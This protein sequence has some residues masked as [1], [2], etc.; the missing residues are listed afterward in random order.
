MEVKIKMMNIFF[1][2]FQLCND[3]LFTKVFTSKK[4]ESVPDQE[5]VPEFC[6]WHFCVSSSNTRKWWIDR[7][8]PKQQKFW[9]C[10]LILSDTRPWSDEIFGYYWTI[11]LCVAWLSPPPLWG[12]L[13]CCKYKH[14]HFGLKLLFQTKGP[15]CDFDVILHHDSW[16]CDQSLVLCWK[17][18]QNLDRALVSGRVWVASVRPGII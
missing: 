3:F 14:R 6:W 4:V 10:T 1:C 5:R 18:W 7:K 2:L 15:W 16:S 13:S 11:I 9:R 12:L 8:Y 17:V